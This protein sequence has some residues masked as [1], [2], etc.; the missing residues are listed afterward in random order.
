VPTFLPV[1]EEG[2]KL[3]VGPQYSSL[4]SALAIGVCEADK[5][6]AFPALPCL[7][8]VHAMCPW[9][10]SIPLFSLLTLSTVFT[11]TAVQRTWLMFGLFSLSFHSPFFFLL[12]NTK[13]HAMFRNEDQI[14]G[15]KATY[16]AVFRGWAGRC[17]A[18]SRL[19]NCCG[20]LALI[21]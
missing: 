9:S 5:P 18:I 11:S 7:R 20:N 6:S 15:Y 19:L 17:I 1:N 14:A 4:S 8:A 12:L 10:S 21:V 2:M 3:F 16:V 13:Y